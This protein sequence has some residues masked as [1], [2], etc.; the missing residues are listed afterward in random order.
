M[1]I[2]QARAIQSGLYAISYIGVFW[3][4][5]LA[6]RSERYW[7]VVTGLHFMIAVVGFPVAIGITLLY[8]GDWIRQEKKR[9]RKES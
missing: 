5:P 2:R 7:E 6:V 9:E 4:A 3:V 8:I 1:T